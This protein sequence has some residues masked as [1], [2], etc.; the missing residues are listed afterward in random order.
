MGQYHENSPLKW[1]S[2]TRN[3]LADSCM[4]FR[5][6]HPIPPSGITRVKYLLPHQFISMATDTIN[7]SNN[8]LNSPKRLKLSLHGLFFSL[9]SNGKDIKYLHL[10]F[11]SH[12]THPSLSW[13]SSAQF[14]KCYSNIKSRLYL[15]NLHHLL[16]LDLQN[17]TPYFRTL[18]WHYIMSYIK[19]IFSSGCLAIRQYT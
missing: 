15:T 19:Y 13:V 12:F 10:I 1:T 16:S 8:P 7:Y 17:V 4:W 9:F 6:A 2:W 11:E 5:V 18:P 14:S 3:D